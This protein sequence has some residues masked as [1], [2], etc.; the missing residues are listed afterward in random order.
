MWS[1]GEAIVVRGLYAG[2]PLYGFAHTVVEDHGKLVV[3]FLRAGSV[4][5]VQPRD[6]HGRYLQRWAEGLPGAAH[7]WKGTDVLWL[8][9]I[10]RRHALGLFWEA[11]TRTF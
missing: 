6:E 1:P 8:H 9:P 11:G 5:V 10:G 2:R 4:G 7:T 3:S